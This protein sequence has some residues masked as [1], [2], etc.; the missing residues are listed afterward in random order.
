MAGP[1][2]AILLMA[3]PKNLPIGA[4]ADAALQKASSACEFVGHRVRMRVA[5]PT[6]SRW[7]FEGVLHRSAGCRTGFYWQ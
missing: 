7:A 2:Y 4:M 1:K 6:V 3:G 5:M